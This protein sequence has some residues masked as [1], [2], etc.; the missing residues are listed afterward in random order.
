MKMLRATTRQDHTTRQDQPTRHSDMDHEKTYAMPALNDTSHN[1]P[2]LSDLSD[3]FRMQALGLAACP[4]SRALA[5]ILSHISAFAFSCRTR[6]PATQ[7]GQ[8]ALA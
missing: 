8:A 3:K 7:S 2:S 5:G 1:Q 4:L 6:C